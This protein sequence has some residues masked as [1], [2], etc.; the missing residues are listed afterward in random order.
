MKKNKIKDLNSLNIY[1]AELENKEIEAMEKLQEN[2]HF[3]KS[4]FGGIVRSSILHKANVEGRA[5][6]LYWLF[7][8][9]EFNTTIGRT[10]EKLTVKLENLLVKWIDKMAD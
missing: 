9:P 5:S 3:L 7:K 6:F 10:A 8:I 4:D 1:I 2:W